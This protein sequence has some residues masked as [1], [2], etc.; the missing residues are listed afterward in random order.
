MQYKS[1]NN[2]KIKEPGE[3]NPSHGFACI[4]L[5]ISDPKKPVPP[6]KISE[7][8]QVSLN[9]LGRDLETHAESGIRI[10]K[11]LIYLKEITPHGQFGELVE[12]A[13][14][15]KEATRTRYMQIAEKFGENMQCR[16]LSQSVLI[17]LSKNNVP[18]SAREEATEHDKLTIKQAKELTKAN[19]L[20]ETLQAKIDNP[21]APDLENLI[22]E[23]SKLF[24]GGS[25][26]L[27][28]A[29]QLS[30]LDHKYQNIYLQEFHSK[31]FHR[32][33]AD[34]AKAES[35]DSMVKALKA[36]EEK[37][38]ALAKLDEAAGTTE[39]SLILKHEKELKV[40]REDA[41]AQAHEIRKKAEK[42]ASELHAKLNE[43]KIKDAHK[44]KDKAEKSKRQ[45]QEKASAAYKAQGELE[46]KIKKLEEQLEV[47]NPTNV[48]LAME[49][50]VQSIT[51]SVQFVLRQLRND[52]LTIGGGMDKSIKAVTSLNEGIAQSLSELVDDSEK[53]ININGV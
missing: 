24:R 48:D 17:E 37:E 41:L 2:L 15:L 23:I 36:I 52:M 13:Y 5:D 19:K 6:I 42:E 12:W 16:M 49:K 51:N 43:E 22:P 26:V 47:N 4:S 45:A 39:A 21:P 1:K 31:E 30:T 46:S 50:Q 33:A 14:G 25:V 44:D 27:A 28:R 32:K 18:E 34:R 7:E 40:L 3:L 38:D 10:G 29:E 53:I 35:A 8:I 20:I 9:R 11:E